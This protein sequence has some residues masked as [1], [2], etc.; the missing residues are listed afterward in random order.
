MAK[1]PDNQISFYQSV[2]GSINIEVMFAEENVWLTQ[3]KMAELFGVDRSV[4]TKH[5]Q[6]IYEEGELDEESTCAK[7]AQV[8]T[9]GARDVKRSTKMYSLE[10]IIAVGY[11]VN[12]ER[13]TEFR[14]WATGILK[15]YIHKGYALDINRMKYGSR[16][17]ARY[18]DELYEEIKDIRTSERMIYQKITDIYA[19][20]L[21]YSPKAFE[22]KQ[23]FATVQNRLH[24]AITGK[25][26]AEIIVGR[27]NSKKDKL[28]LTSWR[29]SPEGKIMP[30]D[31]VIAKNYLDKRELG[32]LNMIG[33]MYLDYAEI[34]AAR[35]KAM[36]MQDWAEKLNAFLKF[37]EYEILTNAGKISH[38]VAEEL[39]LKEYEKFRVEQ[40][41]NYISDFDLIVKKLLPK[42]K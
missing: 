40:D 13:G 29:R 24:F 37:S 2:D 32:H 1:I 5:L 20:A 15:S 35:G 21:D 3:K 14:Q 26:A 31:T 33:N 9:E 11:R 4:V 39:A 8:Q 16:F 18:F 23:F 7:N 10:A 34:Q 17:S 28:G 12:S 41:K 38:E 25:T 30:S 6:N 19:T 42:S 22:S 27:V 36:T